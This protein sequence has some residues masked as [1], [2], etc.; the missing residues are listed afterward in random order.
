MKV[1]PFTNIKLNKS[2]SKIKSRNIFGVVEEKVSN[3]S[4]A[5]LKIIDIRVEEKPTG[6]MSAG[7]GVGTTG[8]SFAINIQ[9]NNWL[10]EGKTSWF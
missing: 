10:G 7:A 5:D 8:G 6:E 1:T 9:E 4:S 3:G 2:I